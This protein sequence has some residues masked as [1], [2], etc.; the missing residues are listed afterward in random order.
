MKV[1]YPPFLESLQKVAPPASRFVATIWTI[2]L[3]AYYFSTVNSDIYL[4]FLCYLGIE[5][6]YRNIIKYQA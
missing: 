3:R 4:T 6:A 2:L 5:R 1:S